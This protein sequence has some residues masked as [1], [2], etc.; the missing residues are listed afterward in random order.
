M[1]KVEISDGRDLGA[2][3]PAALDDYGLDPYEFRIYGR[4][5][6]RC[7]AG[8]TAW[9]SVSNMSIACGMGEQKAK[10]CL[11]LLC[12]VGL[13]ERRS[14]PGH[15]SEYHLLPASRWSDPSGLKAARKEASYHPGA[16]TTQVSKPPTTQVS[17]PPT[18]QVSKPPIKGYQE[19]L[20]GRTTKKKERKKQNEELFFNQEEMEDQEQLEPNP[21]PEVLTGKNSN[22]EFTSEEGEWNGH[23]EERCSAAAAR[24]HNDNDFGITPMTPI[25][26][27]EQSEIDRLEEMVFNGNTIA[28]TELLNLGRAI[29]ARDPFLSKATR[30]WQCFLRPRYFPI[31]QMVWAGPAPRDLTPEVM[32]G[33]DAY[34]TLQLKRPAT[35]GEVA[36]YLTNLIGGLS[37]MKTADEQQTAALALESRYQEGVYLMAQKTASDL[38]VQQ[39]P[40]PV[41][42]F[43]EPIAIAP[44]SQDL[45]ARLSAMGVK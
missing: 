35:E 21:A 31:A 26:P 13:A 42:I 38:V 16:E 9:E 34:R 27:T 28:T 41:A 19:G 3:I 12:M 22:Q 2:I 25:T 43:E 6:R 36:T 10:Q 4:L 33:A 20:P 39:A 14:R 11:R 1:N 8:G 15:S 18:T 5:A 17:K 45:K 32:A 24:T 30:Q 37:R 40:M 7:G 44:P 29:A 23:Q